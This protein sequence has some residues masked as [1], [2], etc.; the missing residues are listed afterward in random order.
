MKND[1][2]KRENLIRAAAGLR[3]V[4]MYVEELFGWGWQD[5]S[6]QNDDGIDGYVIV[7]DRS[8]KD[9]G[10]NIRVQIKSGP[11]YLKVPNGSKSVKIQPYTPTGNLALHMSDYSNSKQPV[12]MV[13]VNTETQTKYSSIIEKLTHPEVWWERMDNYNY[14]NE[15]TITLTHKLG[16][17]SK[18]DWYKTVKD[19]IN[20]WDHYP[21]I[22]M[23][24]H[25]LKLFYS[26]KLQVDA[27]FLYKQ[28]QKYETMCTI[29]K[30]GDLIVKKRRVGWRHI[31]YLKRGSKRIANSLKLLSVAEKIITAPNNCPVM[32]GEKQMKHGDKWEKY[33]YRARVKVD[34]NTELKVQVVLLVNVQSVLN[35]KACDFFSVHIIK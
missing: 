4:K 35:T 8:G 23:D 33:G 27:R 9:L 19:S 7:R 20:D 17:H 30:Y 34:K 16:E 29:K 21:I 10:C 22:T 32:L 25:D 2:N 26:T 6:Q 15:S 13:W 14:N 1:K 3:I 5:I 31:N 18:G 12:I 24:L 11:S 28:W